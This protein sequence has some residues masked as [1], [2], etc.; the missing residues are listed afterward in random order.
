MYALGI[1]PQLGSVERCPPQTVVQV[2]H[3][4][5]QVCYRQFNTYQAKI[6]SNG[7]IL[8]LNCPE[9]DVFM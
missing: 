8:Y 1:G 9:M 3:A 2:R 4:Q 7:S 6:S 5:A